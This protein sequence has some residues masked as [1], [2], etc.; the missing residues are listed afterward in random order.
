MLT[1]VKPILWYRVAL[2]CSLL[3]ASVG[4]GAL[5]T[6]LLG[7]STTLH[8]ERQSPP[9]TSWGLCPSA[10]PKLA[11]D[12]RNSSR[13]LLR[14]PSIG[15]VKWRT[16]LSYGLNV[17]SS[18]AVDQTGNLYLGSLENLFYSL[19]PSGAIRWADRI[20]YWILWSGAAISR[21]GM[22]YD[23][24]MDGRLY[25]FDRSGVEHWRFQLIKLRWNTEGAEQASPA[26]ADDGTV[27]VGATTDMGGKG[28]GESTLYALS[29]VGTQKWALRLLGQQWGCPAI[30]ERRVI[31][32][33][34]TSRLYAL[35]NQG[36]VL[37]S[38]PISSVYSPVVADNGTILVSTKTSL[39]DINPS[40]TTRWE[41]KVKPTIAPALGWDGLIYVGCDDGIVALNADGAIRWRVFR[42]MSATGQAPCVDKDGNV[43]I[44][45]FGAWLCSFT[46]EGATRWRLKLNMEA[47][48]SSPVIGAAGTVYIGGR[49][50]YLY[51]IR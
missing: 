24:C 12:A 49:D 16:Y 29:P 50:R 1:R 20:G 3:L 35:T 51:A 2:I 4:I 22:V 46:P 36:V 41:A 13:S 34:T 14:G 9:L 26:I 5:R 31:Y 23:T 7:L 21:T 19:T 18:P 6:R 10:W 27:Y 43:Y 8:S 32:V 42:G 33:T 11:C 40:G 37:W 38:L 17:M 48:G 15:Q 28:E 39:V 47:T 45:F 30:D 44:G 25:A